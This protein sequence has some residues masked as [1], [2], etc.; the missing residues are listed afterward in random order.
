MDPVARLVQ[1][2]LKDTLG[3]TVVVENI[4]GAATVIAGAETLKS[5]A[6]GHTMLM[7]ANSFA[8]NIT[9]RA[10]TADWQRAFAPVVQATVVPHVLV[11]APS[12]KTD[13]A[14][15]VKRL[16]ENGDSM[17]YGS[18]GIGTS[19][20][21]GS[22][23][24]LRLIGGKSVH[25]P[26]N[27]TSQ[28]FVDLFAGRIDFALSNLPDVV[29]AID[30]GKLLAL[31]VTADRRVRELPNV[32]TFSELGQ[33]DLLSDSWFG[34]MVRRDTP[35][36]A[37]EALERAWLAAL[38]RPDVRERLQSL[39]FTVLARPGAEFET[40]IDR[41]VSTYATIIKESGISVQQ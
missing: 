35:A 37:R 1:E 11:V 23:H 32:P 38:T 21:L 10:R 29:Q 16:R 8:A 7:I 15:F 40:V 5:P 39:S 3:Q 41:Y 12:L 9:L 36:P 17:T 28:L 20:H 24:F 27:G 22:E 34:I 18:P 14:G 26:Y 2:S 6:D 31:A 30:E 13:W 25:A 19:P 33:P 4:A